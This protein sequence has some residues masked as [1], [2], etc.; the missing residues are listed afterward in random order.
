MILNENT[1]KAVVCTIPFIYDIHE[2][3]FM[4]NQITDIM[5]SVILMACFVNPSVKRFSYVCNFARNTFKKTL[6]ELVKEDGNKF[7]ELNLSRSF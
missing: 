3:E 7:T 4:N 2:C 6:C 1:I 5:S